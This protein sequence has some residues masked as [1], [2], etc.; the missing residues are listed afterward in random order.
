M[1]FVRLTCF[2]GEPYLEGFAA[3]CWTPANGQAL[4]RKT[5]HFCLARC[6]GSLSPSVR[7]LHHFSG[8]FRDCACVYSLAFFPFATRTQTR[9]HRLFDL[10]FLQPA[11]PI[12]QI[13]TFQTS[14]NDVL[15]NFGPKVRR[16][17]R[18]GS[19]SVRFFQPH[20]FLQGN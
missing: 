18:R 4:D 19:V 1:P 5:C 11:D 7:C 8:A 10:P 14:S 3:E 2:V 12:M 17:G 9:Y 13:G 6:F 15:A 16:D 20:L